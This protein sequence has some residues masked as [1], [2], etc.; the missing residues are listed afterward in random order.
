MDT[1]VRAATGAVTLDSTHTDVERALRSAG[2]ARCGA[3]DWAI[4][5]ASPD[6][7]VVARLSPFDPVGPYTA[8]LYRAAAPT[9]RVP[10]LFAHRRLAGGGDLQLME[11]LSAVSVPEAQEFLAR[12]E[13]PEPEL[14]ELAALVVEI[15]LEARRDLP[16]CGPLDENPSNIMRNRTGRLVL[17]DPYYADGPDLYA[18]AERDPDLL[19]ARIPETERRFLVDIPLTES[20]P[21]ADAD[22]Q[23][24]REKLR[25][26]DA[27]ERA[28]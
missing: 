8:R 5:L 23:A 19:V 7:D 2:W 9:G 25:R 20:G 26:A 11:R 13:A 24:L 3:G 14:A 12:L 6:G 16:W 10:Q 21:W 4:A 22:R 18:T 17:A 27:R 28:R 1:A 15:H